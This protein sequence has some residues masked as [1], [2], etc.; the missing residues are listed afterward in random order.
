[1]L[2]LR[3]HSWRV[4]VCVLVAMTSASCAV[5]GR[6]LGSARWSECE[7]AYIAHLRGYGL[8]VLTTSGDAG[9]V[10]GVSAR[11]YVFAKPNVTCPLALADAAE[12][13]AAAHV[14]SR[15]LSEP[16]REDLGEP[17]AVFS[18]DWGLGVRTNSRSPGLSLGLR[19]AAR[20]DIDATE[21]AVFVVHHD[22]RDPT[23]TTACFR[24]FEP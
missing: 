16:P 23:A 15:P 3:S 5:D 22:S 4:L 17:L 12:W 8:H 20:V 21:N 2:F 24:R 9:I 10:L 1:V 14:S 7:G 19:N 18:E 11:T 13:V 6:G